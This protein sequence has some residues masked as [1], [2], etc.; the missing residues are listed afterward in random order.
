MANLRPA[1]KKLSISHLWPEPQ[2]QA[3]WEKA[4]HPSDIF[5]R[6]SES[7]HNILTSL[8]K[9]TPDLP[10]NY[11]RFTC[12]CITRSMKLKVSAFR[13]EA[14]VQC[15]TCRTVHSS[16]AWQS[17]LTPFTD[18]IFSPP[19]NQPSRP[20]ENNLDLIVHHFMCNS[21]TRGLC[22][23]SSPLADSRS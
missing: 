7:C 23:Y 8:E 2:L 15:T 18:L 10:E 1:F 21:P 13:C 16:P 14:L 12:V 4:L 5:S 20:L 11:H 17:G 6:L 19:R 3:F 9:D 22:F